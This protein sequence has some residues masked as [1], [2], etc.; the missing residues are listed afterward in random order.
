MDGPEMVWNTARVCD[1]LD[2]GSKLLLARDVVD[3]D[4]GNLESWPFRVGKILT[5]R[6][7]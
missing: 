1:W 3:G 4:W 5:D 7:S 2:G 6:Q